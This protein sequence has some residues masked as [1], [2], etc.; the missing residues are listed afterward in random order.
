MNPIPLGSICS[1]YGGLELGI[2][3]VIPTQTRWVADYEPPTKKNRN[4]AQGAAR[5]L[6]HRYPDV[7]NLGDITIV[8]WPTTKRVKVVCG[9]TPCQD[10]SH[11]GARKGMRT[12]TRSGIWASMVEAITHHRPTLVVWENVGGALSAEADSDVEPCPICVGDERECNLR[13]LGRVLG[14]LAEI[15]YD[16]AWCCVRASDVGAPHRRERVF[17]VAWPGD[18]ARIDSEGRDTAGLE[19]QTGP[20]ARSAGN[21]AGVGPVRPG[22]ARRRG[23]RPADADQ[24]VTDTGGDGRDERRAEP[25]RKLGRLDAAER[26][27]PVEQPIE[28]GPFTAAIQRWESALGRRA[29]RP[30]GLSSRGGQVLSPQFVEW[31]MGLPAGWVTDIPGLTRNDQLKALGNGVV[32]QQAAHAVRFLLG[33]APAWVTVSTGL[34]TPLIHGCA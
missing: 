10:V 33:F 34:S 3:Q 16:S 11:A 15:G 28:W 1:G 17:V 12:G 32:P 5:I 23:A 27:H 25:G 18:P 8:N 7:P 4:P 19:G 20:A 2:S 31:M 26:G 29:P 13:A 6:A 21:A 24:P 9:G 14:D 30:T 22:A